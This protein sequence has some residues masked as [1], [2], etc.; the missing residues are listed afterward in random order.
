MTERVHRVAALCALA[1]FSF[2]LFALSLVKKDGPTMHCV[3][4]V[5]AQ[6]QEMVD[7]VSGVL[8]SFPF[9]VICSYTVDGQEFVLEQTSWVPLVPLMIGLALLVGAVVVFVR[10]RNH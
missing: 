5:S 1:L 9:G 8:T 6:V 3:H 4:L 7:D 2:G 10:S